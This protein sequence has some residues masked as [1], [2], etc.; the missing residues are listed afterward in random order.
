MEF[1]MHTTHELFLICSLEIFDGIPYV[2]LDLGKGNVKYPFDMGAGRV[3]DGRLHHIKI[4]RKSNILK[5]TLDDRNRVHNVATGD[6]YLDLGTMLFV[7]G[8]DYQSRLPWQVWS[9]N[10]MYYRGCVC[11]LKI[12]GG[13]IVNLEKIS[14]ESGIDGGCSTFSTDCQDLPCDNNGM[15]HERWDGFY[16]DCSNTPYTGKNCDKSSLI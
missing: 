5:L 7:G 13:E 8:V 11:G 6:G 12:N 16:C 3:N 14:V 4:D 10:D 9:R 15:C 1:T 2:N